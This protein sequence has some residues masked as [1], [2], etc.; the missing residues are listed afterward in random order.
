MNVVLIKRSTWRTFLGIPIYSY[1][2]PSWAV[3]GR[4]RVVRGVPGPE[5]TQ[6]MLE[7]IPGHLTRALG[8]S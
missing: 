4:N 6:N 5:R 3:S 7:N 2:A 8:L 1:I